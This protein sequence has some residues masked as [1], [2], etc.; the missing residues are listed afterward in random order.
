M[1]D[2][3][4]KGKFLISVNIHGAEERRYFWCSEG[5]NEGAYKK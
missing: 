3:M 1:P 5:S 4:L 2:R